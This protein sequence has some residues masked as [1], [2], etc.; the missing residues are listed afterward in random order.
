MKFQGEEEE[1]ELQQ[2]NKVK[3]FEAYQNTSSFSRFF[4]FI[5]FR[6]QQL[7]WQ[8]PPSR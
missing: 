2:R 3:E 7:P 8:S 5:I 6:F 4:I 1:E